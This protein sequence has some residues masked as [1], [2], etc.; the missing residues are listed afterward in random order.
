MPPE[1]KE[2]K[3]GR[4]DGRRKAYCVPQEKG[5]VHQAAHHNL[6]ILNVRG[7]TFPFRAPHFSVILPSVC[8]QSHKKPTIILK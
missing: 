2:L 7:K 3:D 4:A 6:I 1:R 8:S 5:P